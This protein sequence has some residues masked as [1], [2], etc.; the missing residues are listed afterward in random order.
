MQ[1]NDGNEW[2]IDSEKGLI[3]HRSGFQAEFKGD[4]IY[5]IKHFAIE[6]TIRDIR[7]LVVKAEK[8]LSRINV[9]SDSTD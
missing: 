2:Q 6:A 5:G 3:T 9:Q 8:I 7:D 4:C 1:E